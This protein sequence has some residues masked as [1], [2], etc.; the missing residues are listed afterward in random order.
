MLTASGGLSLAD[1]ASTAMRT[2]FSRS[3]VSWSLGE[4]KKSTSR[5]NNQLAPLCRWRV[6]QTKSRKKGVF[7][8]GGS[9]S[10]LRACPFWEIGVHYFVGRFSFGRRMI[11]E[12]GVFY[13]RWMT[14][15]ILFRKRYKRFVTPYVLQ[16]IAVPPRSQAD[17]GSRSSPAAR[18]YVSCGDKRTSGNAMERG[19]S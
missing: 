5:T 10:R 3:F 19:A 17:M 13:G 11:P 7:D 16:L 9:T 8:P 4:I 1:A 18:G 15:N 6:I 2:M 12:A 14:W